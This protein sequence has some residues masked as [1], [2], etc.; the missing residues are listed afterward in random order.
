[1]TTTRQMAGSATYELRGTNLIVNGE[2]LPVSRDAVLNGVCRWQRATGELVTWT[3][4]VVRIDGD[5]AREILAAERAR[6]VFQLSRVL[7]RAA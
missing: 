3:G 2:R 5:L 4:G 6:S 7:F 1:M